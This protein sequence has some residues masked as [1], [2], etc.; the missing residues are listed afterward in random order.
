MYWINGTF[1]DDIA[2]LLFKERDEDEDEEDDQQFCG[3]DTES[4]DEEK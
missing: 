4:S 2:G 1:P 3:R